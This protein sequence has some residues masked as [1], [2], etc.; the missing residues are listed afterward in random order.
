MKNATTSQIRDILVNSLNRCLEGKLPIEDGKNIIGL[1]NQLNNNMGAE[2]KVN[3][4]K[5][6]VGQQVEEF[7]S[8][9]VN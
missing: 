7:G 2:C 8:L 9:V 1:T 6:S 3:K 4:M 5:L